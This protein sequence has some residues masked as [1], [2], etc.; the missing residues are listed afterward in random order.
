MHGNAKFPRRK[1]L[2]KG[3][4]EEMN[5]YPLTWSEIFENQFYEQ[6][7]RIEVLNSRISILENQ[8]KDLLKQEERSNQK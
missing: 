8:M 7:K 5:K 2:M 1:C 3:A 6:S 4:A